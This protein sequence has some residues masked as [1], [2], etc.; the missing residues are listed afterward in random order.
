MNIYQEGILI[1]SL[2]SFFIFIGLSFVDSKRAIKWIKWYYLLDESEKKNYDPH[3]SLYRIR[4]VLFIVGFAGMLGLLLSIF[5]N[6]LLIFPTFILILL[7]L[8]ISIRYT[9]PS[10]AK[11][12]Y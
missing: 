2:V 9:G 1:I 5:V 3:I 10:S 11:I 6:Q 7:I 4:K 8:I 12:E